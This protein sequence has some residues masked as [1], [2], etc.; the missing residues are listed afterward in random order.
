MKYKNR[1]DL[2]SNLRE[3]AD[4][5]EAHGLELPSDVYM[6]SSYNFLYD[7]HGEYRHNRSAREKAR[8]ITKV[9]ARGGIVEKKFEGGYLELRR[10]F[11]TIVLEFNLSREKVCE[12]K[13]VGYEDVP[14]KTTPAYKREIVE[15]ICT[16]PILREAS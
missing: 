11:G 16:D 1:D 13:T 2:V 7:D 10:K 4:F 14:E 8:S 6:A 12:R 3:L 5:L 15:W 9:L